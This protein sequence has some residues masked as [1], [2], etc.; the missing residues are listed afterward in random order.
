MRLQALICCAGLL[1]VAPRPATGASL[2]GPVTYGCAGGKTFSVERQLRRATVV[3]RGARF[4]LPRRSSGI[5]TRY[6]SREATL[7]I[8]GDFAVFVAPNALDLNACRARRH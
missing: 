6:A 1:L 8:D 3:Y 2:S 7:I 5:G 4:V